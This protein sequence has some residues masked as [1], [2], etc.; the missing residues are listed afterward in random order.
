[1]NKFLMWG[2]T[3][4]GILFVVLAIVYWITPAG[5]LPSY[6]PGFEAGST[7]VH[8]KHGLGALVLAIAFF[9]FAWFQGGPKK[10]H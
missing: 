6:F 1:M 7:T 9:I 4:L 3:I 8:I 2:A 5:S 10:S